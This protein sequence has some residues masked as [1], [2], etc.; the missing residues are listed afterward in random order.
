MYYINKLGMD[1]C[2]LRHPDDST[3]VPRAGMVNGGGWICTLSYWHR[4]RET[5]LEIC[6]LQNSFFFSS[7]RD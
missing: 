2:L 5:K 6:S 1:E 3:P 4:S 7:S